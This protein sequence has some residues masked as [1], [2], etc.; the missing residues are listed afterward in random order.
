M[1]FKIWYPQGR[2]MDVTTDIGMA[3]NYYMDFDGM[4]HTLAGV[5]Q[6]TS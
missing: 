6:M 1:D 4:A 3:V 5:S 2:L